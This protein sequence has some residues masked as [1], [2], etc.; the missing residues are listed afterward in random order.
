MTDT[1]TPCFK[2]LIVDDD[3]KLQ[4]LL[5]EYLEE[6]GLVVASRH[7]GLSIVS[8]IKE[9][10]PDAI[11]LDIMMPGKDGFEVLRELRGHYNVPVI[12][13]T[14]K[15]EEMDRIIGL[16][17]GADDYLPKPFNPRELLARLKAILRRHSRERGE[18]AGEEGESLLKAGPFSLDL[19]GMTITC[20]NEEEEL[21][22]TEFRMVK[23]FMEQP[24]RVFSRDEIMNYAR[25][26][27]TFSFE[28][29]IDVHI[30]KLRAKLGKISGSREWI[31]TAWGR[32]YLFKDET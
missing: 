5:R 27:D 2:I 31:H 32:G 6:F 1:L 7:D 29:S 9:E 23:M 19:Q 26:R 17:M 4:A 16:E 11:I 20:D 14:A 8:D 30:S 22:A 10:S 25:G 15:G 3:I 13:L 18:H 21:S 28:R 24:G 12:M